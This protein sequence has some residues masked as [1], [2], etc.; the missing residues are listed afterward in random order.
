MK[1][2]ILSA[3]ILLGSV[4]AFAQTAPEKGNTAT[5]AI[6]TE[7]PAAQGIATE[8]NASPTVAAP[9]VGYTEIK[10]EEIPVA[11][12]DALKKTYPNAKLT[13]ANINEKKQYRLD[14]EVGNR[15]GSLY[16]DETGNWIQK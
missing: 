6:S 1:K 5:K 13:K 8:A 3:I 9:A 11:L 2:L 16:A 10:A 12:T 7:T 14:V 15:A 4:A